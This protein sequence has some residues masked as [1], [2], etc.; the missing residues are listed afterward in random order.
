MRTSGNLNRAVTL[1]EVL[2]MIAAIAALGFLLLIQIS[3][4][5]PRG[6]ISCTSRLK[7][8]GLA[9]HLFAEDNEGHFPMQV[10]VT[11][12]GSKEFV[13][14]STQMW[15][16]FLALSNELGTPMI[17]V[18]PREAQARIIT[19]SFAT[20]GGA[21]TRGRFSFNQN[22]NVSYFVGVDATVSLTNALLTGDRNFAVDGRP[23]ARTILSLTSNSPVRWTETTHMFSGNVAF[24]DG[25]VHP[26]TTATLRESLSRTGLATSRLALP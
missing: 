3:K 7:N 15:R 5:R 14:D 12:G 1:I 24:A 4:Q 21:A 13:E 22:S 6:Q 8:V 2:G 20:N 11:N 18:C 17:L 19:R 25:S 23:V 10:A 26:S 9:F 16:H